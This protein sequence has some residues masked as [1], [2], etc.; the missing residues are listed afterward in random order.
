MTKQE[1]FKSST[2][3]CALRVIENHRHF[4]DVIM[5]KSVFDAEE[6][7]SKQIE[8][9]YCLQVVC[10]RVAKSRVKFEV[11][12]ALSFDEL[13]K[14]AFP[15]F[16]MGMGE[17]NRILL[18]VFFSAF[19]NI[20][21]EMPD[22]I[23]DAEKAL[24]F[25]EDIGLIKET[26]RS[27]SLIAQIAFVGWFFETIKTT[28]N[29]KG[30]ALDVYDKIKDLEIDD[31]LL[32][33]LEMVMINLTDELEEKYNASASQIIAEY[34]YPMTKLIL[35]KAT[36][37]EIYYKLFDYLASQI[38]SKS[39]KRLKDVSHYTNKN[40][41]E[42]ILN[43]QMLKFSH[44]NI[45]NDL[46]EG[47]LT[48]IKSDSNVKTL[49]F[50]TKKDSLDLWGNYTKFDGVNLIFDKAAIVSLGWF[51]SGKN[52]LWA[53]YN[54]DGTF[55]EY[56]S[57]LQEA[58]LKTLNDA[59]DEI[60]ALNPSAK[61]NVNRALFDIKDI[62]RW[63]FKKSAWEYENEIRFIVTDTLFNQLKKSK[64]SPLNFEIKDGELFIRFPKKVLKEIKLAPYLKH[65]DVYRKGLR[66]FLDKNGY[67]HVLI[68][69]SEANIQK[70]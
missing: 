4:S 33:S 63:I 39:A 31:E 47:K 22:F 40:A 15:L 30:V 52:Q 25:Y 57:D 48:D 29:L 32:F 7:K 27:S 12:F 8:S 46:D 69:E 24:D 38:V 49:S 13:I 70:M 41:L 35:S 1:I 56:D 50:T 36:K 3:D 19:K 26:M 45:L 67:E 62:W 66:E 53:A 23:D 64:L 14:L 5:G 2:A 11:A 65:S 34:I 59:R 44:P 17:G 55:V 37:Y 6:L 54:I 58:F 9:I 51:A 10:K 16:E 43:Q 20:D 28:R 42:S 60:I 18:N 68:T 21:A 61:S